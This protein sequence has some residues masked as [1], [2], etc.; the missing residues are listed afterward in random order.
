MLQAGCRHREFD[1]LLITHPL[2]QAVQQAAAERVAAAHPV[3][4][5]DI[6]LFRFVKLIQSRIE[7]NRRPAVV[8]GRVAF[9]QRDRDFLEAEP[10]HQFAADGLVTTVIDLACFQV[11]VFRLDAKHFFRV[12]FV[13][14][15]DVD[16]GH[17]GAHHRAGFGRA[18]EILAEVQV[19]ADRQAGLFRR[20]HRFQADRRRTV[21]ESRGDAGDMEHRRIG[22]DGRPVKLARLHLGDRRILAVVNHFGCTL[23]CTGLEEV[24]PQTTAFHLDIVG[25]DAVLLQ[26]EFAGQAKF[27]RW[28]L[29]HKI[30]VI[31]ILGQ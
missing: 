16:I 26:K 2:Q 13:G 25:L 28:Q 20:L 19:A 4:D 31:A 9:P 24:D 15:R 1:A 27:G 30:R 5:V 8:R 12:L 29:R 11:R 21:A 7:Q 17:Q 10:F 23:R 18:P 14:D 3:D 6:I 22:E